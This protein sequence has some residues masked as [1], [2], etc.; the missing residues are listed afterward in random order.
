MGYAHRH[1]IVHR[2]VKPAN[3]MI[4]EEGWSVVTDFGIAKVAENRGLTMTGIAVGTPSYMS[5]EQCAAKDIT[6]KSDQYS[7]GIVAYEMLAG[8]QPFEAD[9]AMAIMFAHFH[10]QPKPIHEVRPDCPPDLSAAVMR[11]LEKAPDKRWPSMEAAVSA[12]GAHQL[13]HDDPMRLQLVEI[14]KKGSTREILAQVTPP[15]TSPVPPAKTRQVP[16]AAPTTPMPAPEGAQ[17][18]DRARAE[19]PARRGFHAAHRYPPEYRGD[20]CGGESVL[21]FQQFQHRDCLR[22]WP[23]HRGRA[24]K[25]HD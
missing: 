1:G 17:H 2:D 6:G 5:P 4:D 3:I 25:R 23:G 8:K 21:E 16:E 20:G 7:L 11:M 15:P 22:Q 12:L 14:V 9:S 19:R 13:S 24:G 10:E 18:R